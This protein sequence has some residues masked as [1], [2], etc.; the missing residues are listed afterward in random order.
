[1]PC[2]LLLSVNSVA[3]GAFPCDAE[4]HHTD[5]SNL[6]CSNHSCNQDILESDRTRDH[7]ENTV[8]FLLT[9]LTSITRITS[10]R[11]LLH[12]DGVFT[13]PVHTEAVVMFRTRDVVFSGTFF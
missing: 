9:V 6:N 4:N 2:I 1:M 11:W 10:A 7:I 8:V 13:L 3:S 5:D 12:V